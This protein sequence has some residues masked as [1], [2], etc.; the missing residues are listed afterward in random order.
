MAASENKIVLYSIQKYS[1][2]KPEPNKNHS[3]NLI[4]K[5]IDWF[6]YNTS[7]YWKVFANRL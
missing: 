1:Q 6:L 5:L 2:Q 3:I 7:P 4:F